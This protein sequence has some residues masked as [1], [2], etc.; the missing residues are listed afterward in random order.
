MPPANFTL[1]PTSTTSIRASW[2]EVPQNQ[3]NGNIDGY[4][5]FYRKRL[6]RSEPY[7]SLATEHLNITLLGLKVYTEYTFRLLAYNRKGNGIATRETHITTQES[8][9]ISLHFSWPLQSILILLS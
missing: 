8:G 2:D 4:L 1:M 9:K 6:S 3:Q 7:N 5:L